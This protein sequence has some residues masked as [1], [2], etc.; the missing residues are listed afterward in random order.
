MAIITFPKKTFES[1]IG[2]LDEKMQEKI[3]LFG[4]PIEDISDEVQ[5]EI[6]PNRPDM[7]SYHGFKRA[8]LSFL[9]KKTGLKKYNLKKPG[10]NF[11]VN[12]DSAVKKVR[13]FT[14]CAIVKGLNFNNQKIKEIIEIQEKLHATLGR[15]R[16][17]LAIGIYPL[18]KISLPIKYTVVEPDKIKFTPLESK[19]EMSGLE[20]LEKHP[21]GQEYAHLLAGKTKFPVFVD[22]EKNIMSMPPIINSD[23]TG[24]VTEQTKDVFV[25]CSGFDQE[26]LD[27]CLNIIVTCLAEMGGEIY[28]VEVKGSKKIVTP[29]FSLLKKKIS[30]DN[31][32]KL[33]GVNL[34]EK[35][36]KSC[37][38]KMGH[39]YGKRGVEVAP[40]RIDVMHEV[41]LIED[42]AIAYGYDI[43][44]PE[45]L[46]ASTIGSESHEKK[47]E[48]QISE[49][50]AGLEMIEISSYY[51]TT[52]N[53]QIKK[54]NLPEK[55]KNF[56]EVVDSKT[57]Y[58]L[59]RKDICHCLMR[60][61]SENI[62]SEYPQKIFEIGNVFEIDKEISETRKMGGVVSPGNFTSIKQ[63]VEYFFKMLDL[64]IEIKEPK[65]RV[66][67]FIDGRYAEIFL[68]KKLVGFLGE[69]HPKI[70]K[71]WKIKM[72]VS[73]F[74]LNLDNV[75][76]KVGK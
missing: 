4:T 52:K 45:V 10:E 40:W 70:L 38:E 19:R 54:M 7:L 50:M 64:K 37:L 48:K 27:K 21:V 16:K 59:L 62:D 18:D 74:E 56:V 65:E 15:R 49:I 26:I 17:K 14:S 76:E 57:E 29:N 75:F 51:L 25:E 2:E 11:V 20:I 53:E 69:I 63:I 58:E 5:L 68:D 23:L 71:N 34:N 22:A 3:S 13:P 66:A 32:K 8:F 1:E 9:G 73:L 61:L 46:K 42:V 72:P 24:R 55:D 28:G 6:F 67:Y 36:I 35:Q 12:V 43:F 33:L 44:E 31:V 30:M 47:F 41:D 60:V 39:N